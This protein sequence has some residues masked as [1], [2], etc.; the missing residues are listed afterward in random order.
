[1]RT[2]DQ[3]RAEAAFKCVQARERSEQQADYKR[4]AK[5]FP[6]LILN[7]GLA[8]AV[9]F[10]EGKEKNQALLDDIASAI[11][12]GR[13]RSDYALEVRDCGIGRYQWLTRESLAVAGWIKR[14]AEALLRDPEEDEEPDDGPGDS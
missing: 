13:A 14:Y 6:A 5:R 4:F 8:Q 7:A 11:E 10:A 12:D 1:M 9:A 2:R 3:R